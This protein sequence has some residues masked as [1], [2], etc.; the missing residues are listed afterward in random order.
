MT[1]IGDKMKPSKVEVNKATRVD[2]ADLKSRAKSA[3]SVAA[4]RQIVLELADAVEQMQKR[5]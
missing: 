5:I 4:L 1:K 2:V 3:T